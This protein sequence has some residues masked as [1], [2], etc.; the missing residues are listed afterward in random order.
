[1]MNPPWKRGVQ[2]AVESRTIQQLNLLSWPSALNVGSSENRL[3][4]QLVNLY[5]SYFKAMI[6]DS[7]IQMKLK[8]EGMQYSKIVR[9][10]SR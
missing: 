5:V 7:Y 3:D 8:N 10:V 1:M 6:E 2:K 9:T 4:V